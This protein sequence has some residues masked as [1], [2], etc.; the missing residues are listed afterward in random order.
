MTNPSS[1]DIV[2]QLLKDQPLGVLGTNHQ[3]HPYTSLV[4]FA[5]DEDARCLYFATT[6][7][8]R[9][10]NNLS[11]DQQVAFL[12]D[13]RSSQKMILYEAVAVSAYGQA[14]EV[15]AKD[16]EEALALYLAKHPQLK[17]FVSSPSTALF[18]ISIESYHLVQRFQDVTEFRMDG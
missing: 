1:W 5:A 3:K 13:N 16:R 8:T 18:R 7:A 15:P 17:I 12:I 2:L 11:E 6:R 10:Y 9:K 4:A 14:V